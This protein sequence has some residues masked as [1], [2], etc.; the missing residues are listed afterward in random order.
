[1]FLSG[2]KV[3]SIIRR[4]NAVSSS[5][6]YEGTSGKI[7]SV[8]LLQDEAKP[9]D[10]KEQRNLIKMLGI[11][12]AQ[13]TIISYVAQPNKSQLI[14]DQIVVDKHIGWKGVLK[15]N[16][17]KNF[18]AKKF[19]VLISYYSD[20]NLTLLS[21][22][23]QSAAIFKVGIGA[24]DYDIQDLSIQVTVG[25]ETLFIKELEKYLNILKIKK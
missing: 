1:M 10:V 18:A 6:Q 9:F 19:D 22:S 7:V 15:P 23:A 21:L 24:D 17:L 2:L 11:P 14:D 4:L 13:L 12:E 20:E 25:Q 5:R 8:G 3:K 16:H